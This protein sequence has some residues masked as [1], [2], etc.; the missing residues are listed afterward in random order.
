MNPGR[1][2]RSRHVHLPQ[3]H[4]KLQN[5]MGIR[6][7]LLLRNC[8]LITRL[9]LC[10]RSLQSCFRALFFAFEHYSQNLMQRS[11]IKLASWQCIPLLSLS[12]SPSSLLSGGVVHAGRRVQTVERGKTSQ[13]S[14]QLNQPVCSPWQPRSL[15]TPPPLPPLLSLKVNAVSANHL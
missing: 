13:P 1:Y 11:I 5:L 9:K 14:T 10:S 15:F 8:V 7:I 4:L 3:L 6:R 12:P 2:A